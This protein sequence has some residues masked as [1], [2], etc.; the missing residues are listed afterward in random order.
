[1]PCGACGWM[2]PPI[3]LGFEGRL[4]PWGAGGR[5]KER[6]PG[7]TMVSSWF[8]LETERG[9]SGK[10]TALGEDRRSGR[11]PVGCAG[12]RSHPHPGRRAA[13][14]PPQVY[15]KI[16]VPKGIRF[17]GHPGRR[18]LTKKMCVAS[19]E[20]E[21][22]WVV[23]SFGDL[24]LSNVTGEAPRSGPQAQVKGGAGPYV[25]SGPR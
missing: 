23:L 6:A 9:P 18:H 12:G 24:G 11:W 1:M 7:K 2:A 25:R 8:W 16:S 13:Y 19:G 21:P 22:T 17:V 4:T 20:T 14:L 3:S 15:V 10:S 5:S